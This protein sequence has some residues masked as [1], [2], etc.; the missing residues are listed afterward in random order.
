MQ[1]RSNQAATTRRRR[2]ARATAAGGANRITRAARASQE[3]GD[4]ENQPLSAS[5]NDEAR[6]DAMFESSD[7]EE[8]EVTT[9]DDT[10]TNNAGDAIAGTNYCHGLII[11]F[12][13]FQKN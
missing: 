3:Q 4:S 7:D 11:Y 6:M 10:G 12:Y 5:D 9:G 2:D 8:Q 13:Q 1:R